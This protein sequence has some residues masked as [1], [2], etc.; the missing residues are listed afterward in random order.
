MFK[1]HLLKFFSPKDVSLFFMLINTD[2][3]TE[4]LL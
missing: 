3:K 2:A 1:M 4:K